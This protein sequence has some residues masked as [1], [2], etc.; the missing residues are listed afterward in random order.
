MAEMPALRVNVPAVSPR[1]LIAMDRKSLL[2]A[3]TK[4]MIK[5]AHTELI[6]ASLPNAELIVLAIFRRSP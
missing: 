5:K 6:P 3:E 2:I 1:K 4:D